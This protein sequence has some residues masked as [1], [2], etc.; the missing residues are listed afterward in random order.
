LAECPASAA[1]EV[2][3]EIGAG[4]SELEL[5][6]DCSPGTHLP[7]EGEGEVLEVGVGVLAVAVMRGGLPA[8]R[9]A[10]LE[11]RIL[12]PALPA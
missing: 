5:V 3:L 12:V 4:G 1:G 7:P 10:Y 6:L 11:S 8:D 2:A 9:V